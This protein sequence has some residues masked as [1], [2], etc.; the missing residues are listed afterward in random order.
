[1]SFETNEVRGD[2]TSIISDS[3]GRP[4][5]TDDKWTTASNITVNL[6][7]CDNS[8]G[9]QNRNRYH[10]LYILSEAKEK[11]CIGRF[12]LYLWRRR[13]EE[14]T[15]QSLRR[16]S[17]SSFS[18]CTWLVDVWKVE[19]DSWT[20]GWFGW[21]LFSTWASK[22]YNGHK[23]DASVNGIEKSAKRGYHFWL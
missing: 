17:V 6:T 8:K 18:G 7:V 15:G 14:M 4:E 21:G 9:L 13:D 2:E 23:N 3:N 20:L 12:F 10:M 16:P 22:V 5:P 1:M 19:A 11:W